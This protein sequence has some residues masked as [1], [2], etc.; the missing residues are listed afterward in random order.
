MGARILFLL[1][2]L[3]LAVYAGNIVAGL[4]AVKMGWPIVRLND[5]WE[6]LIV[7]VSMILFVAGLLAVE[8][9]QP[10]EPRKR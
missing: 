5:V 10:E 8:G 4:L 1:T 2:A 6:F 9:K 7:L 3:G